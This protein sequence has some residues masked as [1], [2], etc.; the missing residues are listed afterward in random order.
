[1][2]RPRRDEPGKRPRWELTY[3]DMMSLLLVFF[4]FV[5][6]QDAEP[7]RGVEE[8]VAFAEEEHPREMASLPLETW[9][10][11]LVWLVIGLSIYVLYSRKHS[12][13]RREVNS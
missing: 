6:S 1:M 7:P 12:G 3:G 4:I 11:F 8:N 10:R 5:C 2:P 9:L 13:L